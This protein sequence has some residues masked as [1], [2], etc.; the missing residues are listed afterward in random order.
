[1]K[2]ILAAAAAFTITLVSGCTIVRSNY[3]AMED[4][5]F[6][7]MQLVQLEPPQ[8]G[9]TIA[10]FDTDYGE[11]RTVLYEDYAP[12]TVKA[13]IEKAEAG[14]YDNLPVYGVMTGYYFMSGGHENEKGA[15]TG[16]EDDNGLI[17][18][19]CNVNLWPFRGALMSYSEETGYGDARWFVCDN[20]KEVTE[21]A[22]NQLKESVK[23]R[24]NASERDNLNYLFDKFLEVGGVFG[25]SGVVTVFGQTY[26]GL[27]VVEKLC[28]IETNDSNFPI[29]T[30]MIKSVTISEYSE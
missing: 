11:F 29:E 14:E 25:L 2:K 24:E 20:D 13:F 18:N 28:A 4:Y 19:E 22:I 21:D 30:V 17:L 9:D 26:E 1:M 12:N 10:I 23:N 3:N 6:S 5:D 8:E 16:R 7:Q 27:E 15:Y